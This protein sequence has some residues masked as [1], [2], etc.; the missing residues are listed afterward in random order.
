MSYYLLKILF[1]RSGNKAK[2]GDRDNLQRMN[3]MNEKNVIILTGSY[4]Y[5]YDISHRL[6]DSG[7]LPV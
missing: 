2:R 1:L 3:E 6:N 7:S 5:I 4:T